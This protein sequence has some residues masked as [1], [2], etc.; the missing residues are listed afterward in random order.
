MTEY[1]GLLIDRYDRDITDYFVEETMKRNPGHHAPDGGDDGSQPRSL[2]ITTG[3]GG[4]Q[5]IR[6]AALKDLFAHLTNSRDA[7]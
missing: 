6:S 3:R 4:Y 1:Q 2:D 5:P 7:N